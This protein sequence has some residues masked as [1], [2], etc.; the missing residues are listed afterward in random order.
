MSRRPR[1]RARRNPFDLPHRRSVRVEFAAP[2]RAR[3]SR[4]HRIVSGPTVLTAVG[5]SLKLSAVRLE[6]V[7]PKDRCRTA[8][9]SDGNT[10][11]LVK[12]R[13]DRGGYTVVEIT[14]DSVGPRRRRRSRAGRCV[15]HRRARQR[16]H[17]A[18]PKFTKSPQCLFHL[19]VQ[20]AE[21]RRRS[22]TGATGRCAGWTDTAHEFNGDVRPPAH[23]LERPSAA[24]AP[25]R[26]P[27]VH[28]VP[29][30]RSSVA[31]PARPRRV[32]SPGT[33]ESPRAR[34]S[35]ARCPSGRRR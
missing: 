13:R 33:R 12:A 15:S 35:T 1:A 16:R 28:S 4:R 9:L 29:A 23:R 30:C 21:P 25:Q 3:R 26:L 14:D 18:R 17:E 5:P 7:Q 6:R 8:I 31:R 27:V 34:A 32:R 24:A 10:V 2:S 20:D 19:L 22:K 11:H